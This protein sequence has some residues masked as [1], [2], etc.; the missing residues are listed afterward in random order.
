MKLLPAKMS[1][2]AEP[3][4]SAV[5]AASALVVVTL[6]LVT[7]CGGSKAVSEGTVSKPALAPQVVVDVPKATMPVPGQ[8]IDRIV[9]NVAGRIVLYSELAGQ[10]EQAR[11]SGESVGPE[12]ACAQLE[13]LLYQQLLL[14]QARIDSVVVDEKQVDADLERRIRHFEQQVGGREKLEKFYGK[15]IE[16]IKA[17]FRDQVR[18]QLLGQQMQSKVTGDASV[19]PKEVEKFFNAIPKDSLPFINAAVE[20]GRIVKFAKPSVEED[21][22]VK[23][24]LEDL[25]TRIVE[26][27]VTFEVAATLNSHDEGSAAKGGELGMVPQGVMVPE[28][29]AVALSL[30][31]GEI[32]SVFKTDFG[33]HIMNMIERRGEQYNARHILLKVESTPED[34]RLA[35]VFMDSVA[36]LIRDGKLTFAKAATELNDDEETK[37]TNGL[38]IEPERNSPRWAIGDLD[39]QTFF[40]LD[41]LGVGTLS[42]TQSFELPTGE[43]GYRVFLL[44]KRTE[45][46]AMDLVADYPLV[47][48]AATNAVRQRAVDGWVRDK[49]NGMY[50]RVI[51]DYA[52][53]PFNYPWIPEPTGEK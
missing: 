4:A 52:G 36:T 41:K 19:T 40:V 35:K 12:M 1:S 5:R 17:E 24:K 26:G 16:R 18:D 27:K 10:L 15:P 39:Q 28:F 32:S 38:V 48:E 51:P 29:D 7:G 6:F 30:K 13:D 21:R 37:G 53:C 43:K 45:P 8:V 3:R 34:L 9:A 11:Q 23:K 47:S 33:Y 2:S 44:M 42:A 31:D 20:F 22:R 14:E 49:L 50:V 25:R 46:H